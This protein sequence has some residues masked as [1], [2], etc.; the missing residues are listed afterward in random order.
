MFLLEVKPWKSG[1][2]TAPEGEELVSAD[3]LRLSQGGRRISKGGE[4][5]RGS[6]AQAE[7][8]GGNGVVPEA[9]GGR[10]TSVV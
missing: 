1:K 2:W 4:A 6:V 8:V 7:N 5:R 10:R 3:R 9:S